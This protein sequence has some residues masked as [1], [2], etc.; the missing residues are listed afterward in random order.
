MRDV[1]PSECKQ[2]YKTTKTEIT[3]RE[4]KNKHNCST[5]TEI[6]TKRWQGEDL[7]AKTNIQKKSKAQE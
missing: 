7:I 2:I 6:F 5:K 1:S 3:A 4:R